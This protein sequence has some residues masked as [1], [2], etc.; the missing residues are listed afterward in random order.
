[1]VFRENVDRFSDVSQV[2]WISV[3]WHYYHV[4]ADVLVECLICLNIFFKIKHH[5]DE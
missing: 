1:M 2:V 3:N 4:K 5:E